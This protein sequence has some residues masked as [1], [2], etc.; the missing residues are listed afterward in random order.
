MKNK[1][2]SKCLSCGKKAHN[3]E[4][5]EALSCIPPKHILKFGQFE[6]N[7]DY[8]EELYQKFPLY[9]TEE[10][11]GTY[12]GHNSKYPSQSEWLLEKEEDNGD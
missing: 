1:E 11:L 2:N 12:F 7:K 4:K 10:V 9:N 6:I 3:F 8:R 5:E